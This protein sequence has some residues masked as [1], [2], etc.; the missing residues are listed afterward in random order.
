MVVVVSLSVIRG[1][2]F[3]IDKTTF[4][5]KFNFAQILCQGSINYILFVIK[6][7]YYNAL[8]FLRG[9]L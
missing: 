3:F 9:Q 1:V 7:E 6:K 2:F 8:T 5:Y 4:I